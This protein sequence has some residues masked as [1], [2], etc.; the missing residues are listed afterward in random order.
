[1]TWRVAFLVASLL[2]TLGLIGSSAASLT[3]E[4]PPEAGWGELRVVDLST[5][6]NVATVAFPGAV[7][8]YGC[9]IGNDHALRDGWLAWTAHPEDQGPMLHVVDLE[10]NRTASKAID[11][12]S[13]TGLSVDPPHVVVLEDDGDARW[14]A[15]RYTA[16]LEERGIS[17][18]EVIHGPGHDAHLDGALLL[19]LS[20]PHDPAITIQDLVADR[21]IVED[22]PVPDAGEPPWHLLGGDARWAILS[23]DGDGRDLGRFLEE[24]AKAWAW[25]IGTERIEEVAHPVEVEG[26]EAWL[27]TSV[28]IDR[29]VLYTEAWNLAIPWLPWGL[30]AQALPQEQPRPVDWNGS[31]LNGIEIHDGLVVT[32]AWLDDVPHNPT[33]WTPEVRDTPGPGFAMLAMILAAGTLF[34]GPP[35][36]RGRGSTS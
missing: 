35:T 19:T 30:H 33:V 7:W 18:A 9:G 36:A 5:D 6:E 4:R 34:K 13:P 2:G 8:G 29:G 10:T 24:D 21:T 16:N 17:H 20:D 15:H 28:G 3:C 11:P 32:G 27:G 31:L 22:A 26:R 12:D 25:E 14:T 1:M 23:S